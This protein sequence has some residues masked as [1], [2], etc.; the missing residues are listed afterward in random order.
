[1]RFG[2]SPNRAARSCRLL[3]FVF[4]CA[5]LL[6]SPAAVHAETA[7][8]TTAA[9]VASGSPDLGM[10]GFSLDAFA[11][12]SV[13]GWMED[14]G[15]RS[16]SLE[17]EGKHPYLLASTS[18]KTNEGEYAIMRL[19]GGE[20]RQNLLKYSHISTTV[21]IGGSPDVT[22]TVSLTLYSALSTVTA[23]VEIPGGSWYAISADISEWHLRTGVDLFELRV[24][25]EKGAGAG[26]IAIGALAATGKASLEIADAFLTFGFTADGGTAVYEDGAYLLDAGADGIMTLVAAA[27]GEE[28][29]AGGGTPA[30]KVV[31]A[32]A[33]Q[34]G[35]VSLA[36]SDAFS[37]LSDFD[38]SSSCRLYFGT[39]TY[40]LPFDESLAL[41]AYRLSFR[42]LYAS[43]SANDSVR[44]LSVSLV[45]LPETDNAVYAG[46]ITKC[47]FSDDI[48]ALTVAGTLPAGTVADH[49]NGTLAL[50]EIP[51]W[52]DL[53]TVLAEG[54]PLASMKIS[55]RFT[56][57]LDLKGRE[58][59][60]SVSRYAVILQ[61][62][63]QMIPVSAVRF[64][65][66]PKGDT[67]SVRS[68]VGLSGADTAGVFS[69]NAA[70]VIVDVYVDTLLG[71]VEGNN[72]G[73]LLIRGGR[74]YYL[75]TEYLRALDEEIR[76]YIAADVDVYLRL[77]CGTDL[78]SR[79]F[80]FSRE[81]A[82]FFAFDV[83]NEDGAY[84]LSA[85]TDHLAANYPTLRGFIVGERLDS[86]AYNGADMSDTDAYAALCADTLRVVYNAA[87]VHIPDVSIIAPL[88]HYLAEAGQYTPDSADVSDT[89]LLSVHLS[90][91][92]TAN[93]TMPFGILYT[94]DNSAEMIGHLEN[95][96][97]RMSAVGAATPTELFLLWQPAPTSAS[98]ILLLEY[99]E[100]CEAIARLGVRAFFL[101]VDRQ[102]DKDALYQSLK[103]VEVATDTGRRLHEFAAETLSREPAPRSYT[104]LYT[105][106]DFTKSFST[107]HWI[108][109]SGCDTLTTQAGMIEEGARSMHAAF[110]SD[111]GTQ[112]GKTDGNILCMMPAVLDFTP[113][114]RIVCT[115]LVTSTLESTDTAEIV[116]VFGSADARAEYALTVPVGTPV[117]VLCDLSAYD[118][119]ANVSSAAILVRA[120]SPVTLDV[121]R[122]RCLSNTLTSDELNARFS[123][124]ITGSTDTDDT[125][126]AL[127]LP[128]AVIIL[129]L[130]VSSFSVFALLSRRETGR[131]KNKETL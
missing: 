9:T 7:E 24:H 71:G 121:S 58:A 83:T 88:G 94:S 20:E 29:P 3:A 59:N 33:M 73:R 95:L 118:G 12:G 34:D 122:I 6:L 18:T 131:K 66:L 64:P 100:R 129:C 89:V 91:H 45:Y 105:L 80:S 17:K 106:Y 98:D 68:A 84:M 13:D 53:E 111:D 127:S 79:G 115:L 104:G 99:S 51:V 112:F 130:A 52:S 23:Q 108:A 128:Q 67:R 86:A 35:T 75:D 114:S 42:G 116:F 44:L 1:M 69:S 76:F 22:Y 37:G 40:L 32:N 117:T 97:G 70:N 10:N 96:L 109:G 87:A 92:M 77:L 14:T 15:I 123:A 107:M 48:T 38:I 43:G 124:S 126:F 101:G 30:L 28:P 61:T 27:A 65:D 78:S 60:A 81:G 57:S 41:H 113:A 5:V 36:V 119:A 90:H 102:T 25:D 125:P 82:G 46:K 49:I 103:Y 85:V 21:K 54:E 63:E 19:F 11:D 39:N 56:F 120:A 8:Y 47:A 72:S 110:V 62:E 4:L 2:R 31:L 55:T 26:N 93:G 74:Y 16:I 50:Y